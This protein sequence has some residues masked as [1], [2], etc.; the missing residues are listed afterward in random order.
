MAKH[1]ENDASAT[2]R[3][4]DPRQRRSAGTP[5]AASRELTVTLSRKRIRLVLALGVIVLSV[6]HLLGLI[7]RFHLNHA[8]LYGT[9]D[10]FHFDG[11]ANLPALYATLLLLALSLVVALIAV[12]KRAERDRFA[13]HWIG[14]A[15]ILIY[16]CVDEGAQFH[17]LWTRPMR[18][19][20]DDVGGWL[21]FAWVVPGAL[22]ALVIGLAY[23]RF[24]A[25][26]PPTTARRFIFAGATFLGG[27]IGIES[28]SGW[29]ITERDNDFGYYLLA[30]TEELLEKI[31]VILALDTALAYLARQSPVIRLAFT[32]NGA[33]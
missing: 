26:L 30:A 18:E 20:T 19:L 27:A 24:L 25:H 3:P 21:R 12:R 28:L 6:V 29:Y 9:I 32:R 7:S 5:E 2:A 33:V 31:A 17:E 16:M 10:L 22:L 23:L 11:E 15:L 14:L 13:R 4:V 8:N 1:V